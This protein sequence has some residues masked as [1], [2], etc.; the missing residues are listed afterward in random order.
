MQLVPPNC[1]KGSCR[2]LF[3]ASPG[4]PAKWDDFIV[5]K[6]CGVIVCD[7]GR[8][9]C[10]DCCGEQGSASAFKTMHLPPCRSDMFPSDGLYNVM[11][12]SKGQWTPVHVQINSV[13]Q[14]MLQKEEVNNVCR[15]PEVSQSTAQL[16]EF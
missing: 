6:K 4:F 15:F 13:Q 8:L 12:K 10:G 2:L 16:V 5:R 7:S 11:D 1:F 3:H 9:A 14:G